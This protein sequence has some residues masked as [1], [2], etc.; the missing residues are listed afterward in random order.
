MRRGTDFHLVLLG[1]R[2]NGG[3]M[4]SYR[5]VFRPS[6]DKRAIKGHFLHYPSYLSSGLVSTAS[7]LRPGLT[8]E[9]SPQSLYP[10][11]LPMTHLPQFC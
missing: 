8:L 11:S 10:V 4:C 2:L 1:Q 3:K 7:P 6:E 5:G 9:R